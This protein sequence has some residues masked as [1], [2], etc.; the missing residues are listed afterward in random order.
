MGHPSVQERLKIISEIIT[1]HEDIRGSLVLL[2]QVLQA[3][4]WIDETSNKGAKRDWMEQPS[5]ASLEQQALKAKKPMIQFLPPDLFD[6]SAI[7]TTFNAIVQVFLASYPE[8]KGL[9]KLLDQLDR[10]AGDFMSWI[11][12]VLAEDGEAIVRWAEK[13]ELASSLFYVLITAPLQPFME[14]LSRRASSSFYDKWWQARCPICG[15]TPRVAR[16]RDRRRFL[17]CTYCG[18]EYRSDLF[19]CVNCDN[20][21]PYTLQYM[22]FDDTPAF[23]ID[24]CTRC[25]NYLKVINDQALPEPIP[26]FLADLLTL[27]L[28]VHA[29]H[30][31]LIR[32]G[33]A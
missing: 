21:D 4:L 10:G 8:Q 32:H 1:A 14:E 22:Q 16:L 2:Q 15:Q 31:D 19:L 17:T 24:F 26:G 11:T 12:A 33:A 9:Q 5:L 25:R 20:K 27:D 18:A 3:Q 28:D 6:E 13:Y 29:R 7:T 30:A 23:Q